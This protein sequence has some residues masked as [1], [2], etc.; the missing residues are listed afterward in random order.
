MDVHAAAL[1]IIKGTFLGTCP[2]LTVNPPESAEAFAA[3]HFVVCSQEVAAAGSSGRRLGK[4][5][6]RDRS[7]LDA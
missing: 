4:E 3:G 5:T 6:P 2:S 1:W 7:D